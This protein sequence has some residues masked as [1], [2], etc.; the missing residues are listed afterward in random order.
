MELIS[1]FIALSILMLLSP[2]FIFISLMSL[3]FQGLP[4][5]YKQERVGYKYK[6]F[7]IYKFRSMKKNSG[8]LIT[9]SKDSRITVF[10]KIIRKTKIDEIPQIFNILKGEMRFVGPRPEIPEFVDRNKFKFLQKTKPG[11]SD[12]SSIIFR[13]ETKILERIGGDNPYTKLLPIKLELANYYSRKKSF[14]LD[15]RLVILTI[16][17]IIF[18]K[19]VSK[20]FLLPSLI[21]DIPSIKGFLNR[22]LYY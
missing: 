1:R 9:K 14:L 8:D 13:N 20:F 10:G 22:Y 7:N 18:P 16:I 17:S 4:I 6:T 3:L 12:F 11:I 2:I 19:F 5:F 21:I 15:L